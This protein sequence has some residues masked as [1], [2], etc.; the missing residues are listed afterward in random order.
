MTLPVT[1]PLRESEF[2][3]LLVEDDAALA[4]LLA[5]YLRS[6]GVVVTLAATGDEGLRLAARRRPDVVLLDVMLPDLDGL[7]V[8]RRLRQSSDVPVVM[9]TAR[10]GEYDRVLGLES[11][12]DDYVVKP[13][14][15]PELLARLRAQVRRGRGFGDLRPRV[16]W[17]GPL[18]I[19]TGARAASLEGR[20]LT[21]T[22]LE[23]S[24]LVALAD[25]AGQV[26]SRE[27]IIDRLHGAA[28]DVFDRSIDVHVSRLRQKLGD[29]PRAPRWIKTV[30]GVGYTLALEAP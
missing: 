5:R 20:A 21:L 23:F 19:D 28:D 30:R 10:D 8:C 15:S 14:S 22:T 25:S 6:H 16:V 11:G 3:V 24:L 2:E 29:D 9:L 7:T 1:L 26:L 17:V 27:Q 4:D 12:A 13:F 18:R